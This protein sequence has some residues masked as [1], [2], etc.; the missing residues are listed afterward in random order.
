M[1]LQIRGL[2]AHTRADI[3][4]T[5]PAGGDSVG[6]TVVG[7]VGNVQPMEMLPIG[8]RAV[9]IDL[10]AVHPARAAVCHIQQPT[11]WRN[12]DTAGTP[13]ARVYDLLLPFGADVP[14]FAFSRAL[15]AGLGH[16]EASV[17]A[18]TR[19]WPGTPPASVRNS[20]FASKARTSPVASDTP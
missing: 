8:Q 11:V 10:V 16:V 5:V 14:H 1:S 18:A 9:G 12:R 17:A 4:D 19:A 20:P 2:D 3:Q 13:Q 6:A 15:R 7:R